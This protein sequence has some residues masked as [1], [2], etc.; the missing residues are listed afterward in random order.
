[1]RGVAA[2]TVPPVTYESH[3]DNQEQNPNYLN[4]PFAIRDFSQNQS[5][6]EQLG[7]S[8]GGELVETDFLLSLEDVPDAVRAERPLG[9]I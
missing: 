2:A 5:W 1:M 6:Q 3:N 4:P 7:E 8:N 9:R